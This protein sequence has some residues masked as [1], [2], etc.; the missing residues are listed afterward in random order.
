[1]NV[2][3][4]NSPW[5]RSP[6]PTP[7]APKVSVVVCAYN[8]ASTIGECLE[9]LGRLEYP[10]YEVI[11]V[12]D[13][14]R[15]ATAAIASRYGCRLVQTENR[16]VSSARNTGLAAA[17]G[18]LVAYI[19]AD[20]YPDPHWLRHLATTFRRRGHAAVGGPNL[21]PPG[22]AWLAQCVAN[23][24]GNPVAVLVSG[25]VAE[26][27]PGCNMA[28]RREALRA[29]GGF[30]ARFRVAGDDVDACRRLWRAG[31]TLG[32]NPQAVVWHHRRGSLRSYVKQQYGY[33]LAEAILDRKW[34]EEFGVA[35]EISWYGRGIARALGCRRTRLY[36][37]AGEVGWR[38]WRSLPSMPEWYVLLAGL[39]VLALLG[40]R[41]APLAVAAAPFVVGMLASCVQAVVSGARADFPYATRTLPV[42]CCM[43]VVTAVLHVA[44]PLAW[45]AGRVAA[46]LT[47]RH[48]FAGGEA[49]AWVDDAA[50]A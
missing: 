23:A 46:G 18:E 38:F 1:M 43:H 3:T 17:T 15:D 13:G 12:D 33:G 48:L 44:C 45:L 5:E 19:D 10:E 37:S 29:I 7:P 22:D 40:S 30:D 34:P 49:T 32:F 4:P 28:F 27:I 26:H 36:H 2:T 31:M 20:A 39:G 35:A 25:D 8:A 24:P 6:V 47:R 50:A 11:V 42:R 14:S 21:S 41:S 9:A 16:G